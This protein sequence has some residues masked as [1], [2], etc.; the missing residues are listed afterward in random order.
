MKTFTLSLV[1]CFI[2]LNLYSQNNEDAYA[3]NVSSIDN[4]VTSVYKVVSGEKGEDRNWELHRTIFHP[5]AQIVT[6]YIN[7]QGDYKILF[8]DVEQYVDNYKEYFKENNLHE[9]D[10][11]RKIEIFGNL[12]HVLSTF[13]SYRKPDDSTPY[14][15]GMAS[16]QLY[17]DGK[18]WWIISMYYKNETEKDRIPEKYLPAQ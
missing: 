1:L 12:A 8:N 18:R 13:E 11:N 7:D 16:I 9:V 3:S 2:S 15:Q 6:N 10:V 4:I 17:N 5:E 14:K